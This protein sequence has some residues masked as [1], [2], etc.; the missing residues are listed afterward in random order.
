MDKQCPAGLPNYCYSIGP[1][2]RRP[3]MI[4]RGDSTMYGVNLGRQE[5]KMIDAL[6]AKHGVDR[7]TEAA[8]VGGATKG[9]YSPYADPAHYDDDGAYIGPEVEENDG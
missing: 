6:N 5:R 4:Y 7:R 3:V 8:M 9:W 1:K 2:T